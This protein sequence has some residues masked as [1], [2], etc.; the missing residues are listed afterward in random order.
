MTVVWGSKLGWHWLYSCPTSP[1][2]PLSHT[3]LLPHRW[4]VPRVKPNFTGLE[5][6][7]LASFLGL[8]PLW[9]ICLD[10]GLV[11]PWLIYPF[12]TLVSALTFAL[13]QTTDIRRFS[14]P[15]LRTHQ[16][17]LLNPIKV[18]PQST[19][20]IWKNTSIQQETANTAYP[21][22]KTLTLKGNIFVK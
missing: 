13:W 1:L 5:N 19:I 16:P 10:P 18:P 2:L 3:S 22:H 15:W 6:L 9:R 7:F 14:E 12:A 21:L 17:V 8:R 4:L 20:R 11:L